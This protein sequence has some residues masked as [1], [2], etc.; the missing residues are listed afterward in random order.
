MIFLV[1]IGSDTGVC[2]TKYELLK[3]CLGSIAQSGTSKFLKALK[4]HHHTFLYNCIYEYGIWK[5][6]TLGADNGLIG[7]FGVGFYSA[8]LVAGKVVVSTKSPKSDKQYVWEAVADSSSYVIKE[9]TDPKKMLI[10]GTQITLFV[11]PDEY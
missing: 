8:F 5:T 11:R 4:V 3:D 6:K 10:R 2:M 9:E 1:A 7:Q